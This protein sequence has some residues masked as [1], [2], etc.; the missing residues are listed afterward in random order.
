M[1]NSTEVK[2]AADE[3]VS[4]GQ[5]VEM[6][7]KIKLELPLGWVKPNAPEYGV[8]STFVRDKA[9]EILDRWNV[10]DRKWI[11]EGEASRQV[12][13]DGHVSDVE[14]DAGEYGYYAINEADDM[15]LGLSIVV[16]P[17]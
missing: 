13:L 12:F 1:S 11:G 8:I 17:R 10:H 7:V 2:R 6:T 16:V 9:Y 14:I 5:T 4:P 3:A 15:R